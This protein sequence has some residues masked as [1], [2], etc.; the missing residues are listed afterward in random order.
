MLDSNDI[1]NQGK[2]VAILTDNDP[3][4][5]LYAW[6]RALP[7]L[8][9]Q[10]RVIGL[11]LF[12][13]KSSKIKDDPKWYLK[14][15]GVW[16][17]T[18]LGLF[19]VIGRLSRILRPN[20]LKDFAMLAKRENVLLFEAPNP[21]SQ[22]L[23]EWMTKEKIDIVLIMVSFIIKPSMID[24]PSLGIL[25]KHAS[26]LPANR[27]LFPYFWA[28]LKREPQGISFHMINAKIDKGEVILSRK[29]PTSV[30]TSMIRFYSHIF[31]VFPQLVLE[32][33]KLLSEGRRSVE[34][35]LPSTYH[36]R[37]IAEDY[38]EFRRRGGHIIKLSDLIYAWRM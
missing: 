4:W 14:T 17:F 25:N 12:P 23:L 31:D 38:K 32:A 33:T 13:K 21:E 18:K 20:R 11:W 6:E 30:C 8:K 10:H 1:K 3:L 27:G 19:K 22:S 37:P 28:Y 16:N 29:V 15:F 2:R 24:A 26:I 9:T 7:L 36:G 34:Q 35:P 5:S